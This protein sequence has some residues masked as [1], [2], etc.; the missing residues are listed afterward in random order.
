[1][2]DRRHTPRRWPCRWVDDTSLDSQRLGFDSLLG[3]HFFSY[4][5]VLK[6]NNILGL[7]GTRDPRKLVVVE[8]KAIV[9]FEDGRGYSLLSP[10]QMTYHPGPSRRTSQ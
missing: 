9:S 10:S 6:E 5:T 1:M 3:H 2:Y 7:F 4:T 8:S